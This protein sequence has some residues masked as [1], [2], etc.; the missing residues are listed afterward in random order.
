MPCNGYGPSVRPRISVRRTPQLLR[1]SSAT[2]LLQAPL[3]G[4]L[5]RTC[6]DAAPLDVERLAQLR[7]EPLDGQL[8][9]AELAALVLGDRA[10]HEAGLRRH[11]PLL[12]RRERGRGLDVEHG[13]HARGRLLR[14]L[15]A[16]PARAGHA[17]LDL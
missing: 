1:R 16:G 13:L 4:G 12:R 7:D 5:A 14:V 10:Q 11:A 6:R 17:Q 15:A 3:D 2:L 8:P 9:V